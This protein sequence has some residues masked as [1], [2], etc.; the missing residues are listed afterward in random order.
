MGD[1]YFSKLT[2][3]LQKNSKYNSRWGSCEQFE[4]Y[5]VNK[6][7][8]C[9]LYHASNARKLEGG[10]RFVSQRNRVVDDL[11][12][13]LNNCKV[14]QKFFNSGVPSF[15][16]K[17]SW[18]FEKMLLAWLIW[19][20]WWNLIRDN[21]S[22]MAIVTMAHHRQIHSNRYLHPIRKVTNETSCKVHSPRF[23]PVDVY[24]TQ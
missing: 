22:Q 8:H 10:S 2:T 3:I 12:V 9:L 16:R 17:T 6:V 18:I 7:F 24:I 21:I 14:N 20:E 1:Y 19:V 5:E 15:V 23:Q 4:H 13:W 11:T